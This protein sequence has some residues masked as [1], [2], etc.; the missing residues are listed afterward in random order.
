M[1]FWVTVVSLV[2]LLEKPAK[3]A[4]KTVI[5]HAAN[6]KKL[7][8][9]NNIAQLPNPIIPQKPEL[10]P[11]KP[12]QSQPTPLETNP[13][14]LQPGEISPQI[15]G[16]IRVEGFEFE[17][18]T[19]FSDRQLAEVTKP[20]TAREITFA[21][22]IAVETAVTE[23]Y[24]EAGYINSGAVISANQTFPR[25][26]GVVKIQIIEGELTEINIIGN[27]RLNSHY[28]RSRL[29]I[30]TKKPLN[31]NRLLEALQILQLDP[32]ITNISAEIQ[33]GI[34]PQQS[35]LLV[36]VKEADTFNA[37]IF[38][39]N[40]RS[41]SVGSWRRGIKINQSN[42]LGWGDGLEVS[43]TNS[44][45]SNAFDGSYTLPINARN[46]TIEFAAG[47]TNTNVIEQPFNRLDIEGKSR[48]YQLTYRQP[49]VQKPNQELALGLTFS[50]QESQTSLL[51][52]RFP[53]SPGANNQGETS[54]SALRFFQEY[55][56][57]SPRQVLA[58]RSQFSLGTDL[59]GATVNNNAPDSRFFAWRGQGQ[60]VRLLAPETL[61]IL[62]SD[63]QIASDSLLS[64]EQ[65]GI[66]GAKSVRGYSQDLI[67]TDSGA[68]ASAELRIPILRIPEAKG[69]LQVAPFLDF[70]VGWNYAGEKA[71]SQSN[72]LL[73]TGLGLIWQMSD[74]LN[75]RLDYG[76]P[77]ID[78]KANNQNLQ[79]QGLY[80][81][82][83][84]FLF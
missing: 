16:T 34:R 77:L 69:V 36:R 22:L 62:R 44:D 43:Y 8:L 39:D 53:L 74:R 28:V 4:T 45:G 9:T 40:N 65:I 30:A 81:T 63:I 68:I 70:G 84:Y 51:N 15:P 26:G 11:V 50:R 41:P 64:L 17:G 27:R 25:T 23:K 80:F 31:R 5:S 46:G 37:E 3:S 72:N 75:A 35:R 61:L 19:A 2:T 49:V 82:I 58:V 10:T 66:G 32:L 71:N 6:L 33:P 67:L 38:T 79:D 24:I 7:A 55:V 56:Q 13:P 12:E 54:V 76:I 20:F 48:T 52:E 14:T 73:G 83:N 42:L 78:V 59:F 47:I 18:N 21:E 1:L 29:E 60:Y 57:R